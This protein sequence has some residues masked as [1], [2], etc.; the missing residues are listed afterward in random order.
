MIS[1]LADRAMR[2]GKSTVRLTYRKS[3][4][5]APALAFFEQLRAGTP[6]DA[7]QTIDRPAAILATLQYTPGDHA[8]TVETGDRGSQAGAFG[9][10]NFSSALQRLADDFTTV[11]AIVAA[12]HARQVSPSPLPME[13]AMSPD[14]NTLEHALS[15][16][17][18]K[19]LGRSH[20]GLNENFFDAGGT[21]LKAVVVVAMIR[22]ELKKDVSIVSLF[23]SPTIKLL[24][25]RLDDSSG[26][27]SASAEAAGSRGRQRR[28]KLMKRGGRST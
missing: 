10:A 17:W 3:D 24:A 25:A 6:A 20:V 28:Q 5:N 2:A 7:S 22:K 27:K 8:P 9:V 15:T 26:A 21:S 18:K 1:D 13:E 19:A 23:E 4:R 14:G 11:D 16:I 12:I